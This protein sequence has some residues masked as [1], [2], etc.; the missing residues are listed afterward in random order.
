[1]HEISVLQKTF[2]SYNKRHFLDVLV[3]K[4]DSVFSTL[5]LRKDFSVSLPPFANS[6]HPRQQKISAFHYF[7]YRLSKFFSNFISLRSE[8]D[9]FKPIALSHGYNR[10]I[11]ANVLRKLPKQKIVSTLKCHSFTPKS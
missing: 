11:I 7:V 6:N 5:L 10:F 1:M 2:Y 3:S 9:V 4:D 8:N